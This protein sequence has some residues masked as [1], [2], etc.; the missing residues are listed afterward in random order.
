MNKSCCMII[1]TVPDAI[2]A[3]AL[4]KAAAEQRLA[5]CVQ[6]IPNLLS[7]YHWKGKLEVSEEC[8]LQFKTLDE[9]AADLM[10]MIK[11]EHSY[12]TPEIIKVGIHAIDQ[13]YAEWV[14]SSV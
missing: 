11:S 8:Q 5:A 1:T 6:V 12:E 3:E 4:A 7:Y 13:D 14:I 9:R 2:E 10:E